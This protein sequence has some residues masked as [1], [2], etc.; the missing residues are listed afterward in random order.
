M[1]APAAMPSGPRGKPAAG[2]AAGMEVLAV[3]DTTAMHWLEDRLCTV[4]LIWSVLGDVFLAMLLIDTAGESSLLVFVDPPPHSSLACIPGRR[5]G[6]MPNADVPHRRLR[7]SSHHARISTAAPSTLPLAFTAVLLLLPCLATLGLLVAHKSASCSGGRAWRCVCSLPAAAVG[8][9]MMDFSLL[10]LAIWPQSDRYCL[11]DLA[12]ADSYRAARRARQQLPLARP[13]AAGWVGAAAAPC[14][15]RHAQH[16]LLFPSPLPSPQAPAAAAAA[17]AAPAAAGALHAG[18]QAPVSHHSGGGGGARHASALRQRR[19]A[20]LQVSAARGR[21]GCCRAAAKLAWLPP[22]WIA[23]PAWQP[24][25]AVQPRG[26]HHLRRL[27][28]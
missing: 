4:T 27:H 6:R 14:P 1:L 12:F 2:A 16:D 15:G 24:A 17:L 7:A 13:L 26:A 22:R 23:A 9:L 11:D 10:V 18:R 3:P 28:H 5:V 19:A 8:L 21:P 25:G 20:A